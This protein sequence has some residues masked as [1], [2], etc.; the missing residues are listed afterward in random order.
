MHDVQPNDSD[1]KDESPMFDTADLISLGHGMGSLRYEERK[2]C[3]DLL[4]SL[5]DCDDLADLKGCL[6]SINDYNK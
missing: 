4:R 1:Q 6:R 5:M 2:Y 3:C